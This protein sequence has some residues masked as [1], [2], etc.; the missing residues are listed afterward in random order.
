MLVRNGSGTVRR[1]MGFSA[2]GAPKH[3]QLACP[4]LLCGHICDEIGKSDQHPRVRW[5]EPPRR[6]ECL[7]D[8]KRAGKI[9]P[10]LFWRRAIR[11]LFV[12]GTRVWSRPCNI[13]QTSTCPSLRVLKP[14]I[15]EISLKGRGI[16][17]D[18]RE[19]VVINAPICTLSYARKRGTC[20]PRGNVLEFNGRCGL[21]ERGDTGFIQ[22]T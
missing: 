9:G 7:R 18:H 11:N 1:R 21:S 19:F 6:V 12:G 16:S 3:K 10:S 14:P 5:R 22:V 20:L 4:A 15:S 8:L 17:L 2:H 13:G